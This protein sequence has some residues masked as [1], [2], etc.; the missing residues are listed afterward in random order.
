MRTVRPTRITMQITR[1][2]SSLI[3]TIAQMGGAWKCKFPANQQSSQL[4][5]TTVH[6][7][8]ILAKMFCALSGKYC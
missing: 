3:K 6:G 7:E 5:H 2:I 8:V 4:I 1:A